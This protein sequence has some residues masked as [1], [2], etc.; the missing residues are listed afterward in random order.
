MWFFAYKSLPRLLF[1][2][3]CLPGDQSHPFAQPTINP[4]ACCICW[5]GSLGRA[6]FPRWN[7]GPN[8]GSYSVWLFAT[9]WTIAHQA[10]LSMGF[11]RQEYW[12]G[13]PF[14]SPFLEWVSISYSRGSSQPEDWIQVS[15]VF[16][17]GRRILYHCTTW[18]ARLLLW[19]IMWEVS[20]EKYIWKWNGYVRLRS[21]QPFSKQCLW[22]NCNPAGPCGYLCQVYN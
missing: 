12:G 5:A 1:C 20:G 16:C 17:I 7:E 18:E 13:L 14:L 21:H 10:P 4:L 3:L 15:C 9:P 2:V 19:V 6:V 8:F 22:T 11:S